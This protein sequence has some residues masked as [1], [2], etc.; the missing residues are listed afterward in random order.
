MKFADGRRQ[1]LWLVM[2]A[3][4]STIVVL[5]RLAIDGQITAGRLLA[6]LTA[7]A[8]LVPLFS[9]KRHHPRS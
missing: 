7:I 6:D 5:G 1:W 9:V 3:L 2:V 8:L 4:G